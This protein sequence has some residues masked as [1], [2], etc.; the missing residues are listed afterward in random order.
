MNYIPNIYLAKDS[1]QFWISVMNIII[2]KVPIKNHKE[3]F[4]TIIRTIIPLKENLDS[5]DDRHEGVVFKCSLGVDNIDVQLNNLLVKLVFDGES[6]KD[7]KERLD[8]LKSF[9]KPTFC[10]HFAKSLYT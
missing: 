1:L 3:D 7:V 2:A 10:L 5:L 6:N 4:L 8:I 9:K